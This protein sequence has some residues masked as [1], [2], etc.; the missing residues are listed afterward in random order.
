MSEPGKVWLICG[1]APGWRKRWLRVL[2]VAVTHNGRQ[3]ET[4]YQ[5]LTASETD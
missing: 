5:K 2:S 4:T 1:G 3:S